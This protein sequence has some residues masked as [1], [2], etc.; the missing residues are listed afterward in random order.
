MGL[1]S[2]KKF[3][4]ETLGFKIDENRFTKAIELAGHGHI[5]EAIK[6]LFGGVDSADMHW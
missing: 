2:I 3:F 1:D 4:K 6:V 5:W